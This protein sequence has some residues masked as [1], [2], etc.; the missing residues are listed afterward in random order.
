MME[1]LDRL[2]PASDLVFRSLFSLIF[3]VSGLGHFFRQEHMV[4][5]LLNSPGA[6]LAT[7]VAPASLLISATGA[8]LV[9]GG[10]ALLVGIGSRFAALALL[11]ALLPIT[12]TVHIGPGPEHIGPLFKNLALIGG[13]VHFLVHGAGAY[14]IERRGALTD[15]QVGDVA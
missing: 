8:L 5:R 7:A 14:S 12:F 11:G 2:K 6:G 3:V 4:E 15:S 1:R 13:L 10:L 9:L